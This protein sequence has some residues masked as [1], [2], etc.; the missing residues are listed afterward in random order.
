MEVQGDAAVG[1]DEEDGAGLAELLGSAAKAGTIRHVRIR[2][3]STTLGMNPSGKKIRDLH[4]SLNSGG[5]MSAR[6]AQVLPG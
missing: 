1:A 4:L 3:Q 5:M 2:T 6:V